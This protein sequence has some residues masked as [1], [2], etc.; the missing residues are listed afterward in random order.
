ME[1]KLA[2]KSIEGW[3]NTCTH[4]HSHAGGARSH[5]RGIPWRLK[6]SVGKFSNRLR[7]KKRGES[8]IYVS[9]KR[10]TL[11]FET[12]KIFAKLKVHEKQFSFRE[13]YPITRG[14]SPK[15]GGKSPSQVV[16]Q[17]FRRRSRRDSP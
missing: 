9:I 11:N 14:S 7:K 17:K 16:R 4:A 10:F 3:E 15:R 5:F 2:D 13:S 12:D 8:N 6:F 1:W